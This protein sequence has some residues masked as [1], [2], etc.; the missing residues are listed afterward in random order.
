ME[1]E[2]QLLRDLT[3]PEA[4]ALQGILHLAGDIVVSYTQLP[5]VDPTIKQMVL[6]N[7]A[8][9]LSETKDDILTTIDHALTMHAYHAPLEPGLQEL[10]VF[11]FNLKE[12]LQ[13]V[14]KTDAEAAIAAEYFSSFNEEEGDDGDGPEDLQ[15]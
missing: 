4:K 8:I 6:D 12:A 11:G 10:D 5:E 2:A 13:S 7:I 9:S 14:L 15:S 3:E 1:Y